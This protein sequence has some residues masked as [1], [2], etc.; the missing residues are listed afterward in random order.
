MP[1]RFGSRRGAV[2]QLVHA[3]LAP[4]AQALQSVLAAAALQ[5]AGL[6]LAA[7][8]KVLSQLE[9]AKPESGLGAAS[10]QAPESLAAHAL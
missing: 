7:H 2:K 8:A 10:E 5:L 1:G 4:A 3:H 9:P 6:V